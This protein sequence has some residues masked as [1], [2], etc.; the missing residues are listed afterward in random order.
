MFE[1]KIEIYFGF[2]V[3]EHGF[4]KIPEY[5]YVREV[6]NDFIKNDIVIKLIFDG[7]Y[8]VEIIKLKHT[9]SDLLNFNK[10]SVE[11]DYDDYRSYYLHDLKKLNANSLEEL[12][13]TV[14]E[15]IELLDFNIEAFAIKYKVLNFFKN[16]F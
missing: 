15:N 8:T 1:S 14:K 9:D 5:N 13:K 2:L 11:L 7:D 6:H 10:K 12:S 3:K 4:I 16:L